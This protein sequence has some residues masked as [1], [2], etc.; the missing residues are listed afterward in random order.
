VQKEETPVMPNKK[1]CLS[2]T[3]HSQQKIT[4]YPKIGLFKFKIGHVICIDHELCTP[5]LF[6]LIM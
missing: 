3:W 6:Q 1:R 4:G 2:N 5:L